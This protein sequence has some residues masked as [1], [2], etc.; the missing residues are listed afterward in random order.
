MKITYD[1]EVDAMYVY[2]R[3]GRISKT[4]EIGANF[5]ADLDSRGNILGMEILNA[6]KYI[7]ERREKPRISIGSKSFSLPVPV[8]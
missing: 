1:K 4:L 7:S 2:F 3:K 8:G 6:S 5:L